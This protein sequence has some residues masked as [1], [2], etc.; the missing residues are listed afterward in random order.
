MTAK[1]YLSQARFLD[2]RINSKIQQI[3]SLNEPCNKMHS[4]NFGYATRSQQRWLYNG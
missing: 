4:H 2:D 3:S 1:E